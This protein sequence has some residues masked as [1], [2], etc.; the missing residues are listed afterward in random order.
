MASVRGRKFGTGPG[1]AA[2]EAT[3]GAA[4]GASGKPE[5]GE[6]VAVADVEEVL[7]GL[8]RQIERLNV[9]ACR[10]RSHATR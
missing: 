6:R 10:G 3:P 4:S 8:I 9:G 5:E 2:G 1:I 7:T